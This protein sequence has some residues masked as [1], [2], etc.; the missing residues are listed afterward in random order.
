MAEASA[1]LAM[2]D[3][4]KRI[5]DEVIAAA[6]PRSGALYANKADIGRTGR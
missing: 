1:T 5:A 6:P 4:A 2:P 3:A